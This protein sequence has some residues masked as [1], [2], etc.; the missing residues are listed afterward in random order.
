MLQLSPS[1]L[2]RFESKFEKTEGCWLWTGS[3]SKDEYGRF[4]FNSQ[5][6]KAHRLSYLIYKGA[7]PEGLE[8]CHTAIIC[9]NRACVNP[10]HL[11]AKTRKENQ[12][13]RALDGTS[14]RGERGWKA[15]LTKEDVCEI[16][17]LLA[18]GDLLQRE[19]GELYGVG[20]R[21]ITSIKLGQNWKHLL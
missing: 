3:V 9:H 17:K 12:A 15:K 13:D 21:T 2:A 20:E 1:D 16:K 10:A 5:M 18:E 4:G 11:T 7:I 19:I 8:I 6:Y 14:N